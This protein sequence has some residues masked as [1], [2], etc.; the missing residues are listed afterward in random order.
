MIGLLG[1]GVIFT[2]AFF[3]VILELEAR[4]NGK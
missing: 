1:L 4:L 3:Y 2:M